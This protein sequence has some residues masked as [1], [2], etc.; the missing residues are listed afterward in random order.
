L[1]YCSAFL[2]L[3]CIS[4]FLASFS[5]PLFLIP[6]RPT[7]LTTGPPVSCAGLKL[8]MNFIASDFL[9]L[10]LP[11]SSLAGAKVQPFP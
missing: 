10:T 6:V 1:Y 2:F 11:L 8:S 9:S 5:F 7:S 3:C 4:G